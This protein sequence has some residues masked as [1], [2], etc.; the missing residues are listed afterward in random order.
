[1]RKLSMICCGQPRAPQMP[2][3]P[4]G[5]TAGRWP[6]SRATSVLFLLGSSEM[7]FSPLQ[8]P[9]ASGAYIAE[10]SQSDEP[11]GFFGGAFGVARRGVGTAALLFGL[12]EQD[13]DRLV[14]VDALDGFGQKRGD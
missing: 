7:T 9:T 10:R 4:S 3:P 14:V 6:S 11:V 8:A 5:S 2:P 1:M 12:I 13:A